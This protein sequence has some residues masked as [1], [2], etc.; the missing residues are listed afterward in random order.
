MKQLTVVACVLSLF[1]VPRQGSAQE[2]H[3][4]HKGSSSKAGTVNFETSCSPAV[5][6]DFN[7]AVAELHSFWFPEARALFEG[8]L[9]A[10][11][12]RH[13]LLG[14]R[15][16]ALGQ[17]VCRPALAAD[18]CQRQGRDRQGPSRPGAPTAREKG[19]IDAVAVLFS[20]NDV[21]HAARARRRLRR[22]HRAGREPEPQRHGGA[23]LLGAGHRADGA[24]HRQDV[25]AEPARRRNPGA[26]LREEPESSRSWRTTSSTPTTC[27]RWRPRRCRR[28][29]PMPTSPRRCRTR[30]ICRR[31]PSPASASGRNRSRPTSGP[32]PKPTRPA[33]DGRSDCTP[34]DYMTYGYLQMAHGHA[35]QGVVDHAEAAAS[36]AAARRCDRRGGA[37]SFALAA[38]PARY[39]MERQQWAD[40]AKLAPSAAPNT[41]YTEAITYFARAIGAARSG[42]P[43]DAAAD[44]ARLAAIHD[45]ETR[46]EGRVLGRAGGHPA[47]RGRSVGAVRRRARRTTASSALAAAADAED[48]DR[49]VGGDARPARAGAR[50]ARL[51]AARSRPTEGSAG[52]VRRNRSR[53]S[54]TASSR[55]MAP[56]RR[57]KR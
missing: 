10:T 15:A 13:R 8:V 55:S 48:A 51:H 19:Y 14:H 41:P 57:P 16:D 12:L 22:R 17:S 31:T 34:C 39:A 29:A 7:L 2:D 4:H 44:I 3:W 25:R 23:D 20:N 33:A 28:R 26:A 18:H 1:A 27:R 40:A 36:K 9:K 43:A 45:R 42:K 56:A 53:R 50:A 35:G 47:P 30:S 46:D 49:Q 5:K 6:D 24:A 54:R 38:I 21:D 52:G 32:R 11:R 37:N